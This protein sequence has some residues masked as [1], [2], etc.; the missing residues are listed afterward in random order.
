M[1]R[2]GLAAVAALALAPSTAQA[3]ITLGGP[4]P[5]S[6][7]PESTGNVTLT[8]TRDCLLQLGTANVPVELVYGTAT[9]A[10]A[11]TA[12]MS[13]ALNCTLLGTATANI[14]VAIADD[15]AFEGDE[16]FTVKLG[17]PTA[18]TLGVNEQAITIT[19]DDT[20]PSISIAAAHVAEGTGSGTTN[21]DLPI[22]LSK[23]AGKATTV[24]YTLAAGTATP[25][26]DFTATGG[27]ITVGPGQSTGVLR[28]PVK[29]DNLDEPNETLTA[30]LASPAGATLGTATA[31][32]T[33]DNDDAPHVAVGAVAAVEGTGPGTTTFAF[34]ITLSNPSARDVTVPYQTVPVTSASVPLATRAS[35]DDYTAVG[36]A[37]V[38]FAPGELSKTVNV[39]IVRDAVAE[40]DEVFALL[41]G[42]AF[43]LA[44]IKNDDAAVVL[45]PPPPAAGGGSTVIEPKAAIGAL[46][47]KKPR[48]MT[49]PLTCPATV[50]TCRTTLTVFTVPAR[51]SKVKSLRKELRLGRRT[52]TIARGQS[53]SVTITLSAKNARLVK[54]GKRVKVRVYAVVTDADGNAGTS[55]K[56]AAISG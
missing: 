13:V 1:L 51:R 48:T 3:A 50:S 35:A 17:T 39:S 16:A 12:T 44:A 34:P 19:D 27:T 2:I 56:S 26:T 10:D 49:I 9:A 47:F 38:T 31:T 7:V 55:S 29:K 33:I 25:D 45:P 14:V 21:L 18:D 23:A 37:T 20:A 46:K 43:G 41:A 32:G 53:L 5:A 8:V 6:P 36:P 30:T 4:N 52:V 40:A 22:T 42:D 28:V 11:A 54:Q 24:A 15:A